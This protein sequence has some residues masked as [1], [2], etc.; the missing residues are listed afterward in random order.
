MTEHVLL[1]INAVLS[2]F[3][4]GLIWTI[5][6]VHYPLFLRVPER[7][8]AAYEKEHQWRVSVLVMV[9]MP[10]EVLATAALLW[11]NMTN[12]LYLLAALM[13]V[14]VWLSTAVLQGP[15]H[16]RIERTYDRRLIRRLVDTNWI[17]TIAWTVRSILL[18]VAMVLHG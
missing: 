2:W 12:P 18:A 11:S 16:G 9:A 14:I 15:I 4:T 8:F 5:Q 1:L 13:V 10:L 6:V 17:R 7:D 3:L